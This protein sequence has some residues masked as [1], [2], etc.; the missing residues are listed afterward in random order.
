[1]LQIRSYGS[2]V[3][4]RHD[5]HTLCWLSLELEG[6]QPEGNKGDSRR[7]GRER[8]AES[9]ELP[10]GRAHRASSE[11]RVGKRT[12]PCHCHCKLELEDSADGMLGPESSETGRTRSQ[13][14]LL[15]VYRTDTLTVERIIM[16]SFVLILADAKIRHWVNHCRVRRSSTSK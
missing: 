6:S 9:A 5:K 3:V 14:S 15:Y 4:L 12:E 13:H 10:R 7:G 16:L 11:N 8:A 2:A 1:M